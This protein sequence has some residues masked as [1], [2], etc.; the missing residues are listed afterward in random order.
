MGEK[1]L[2]GR[3]AMEKLVGS[4]GTWLKGQA[5]NRQLQKEP[6]SSDSLAQVL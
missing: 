2:I 5:R 6:E 4:N 3:Q 1:K